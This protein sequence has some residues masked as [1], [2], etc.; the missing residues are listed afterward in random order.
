MVLDVG[1]LTEPITVAIKKISHALGWAVEPLQTVRIAKAEVKARA[2]LA[3]GDMDVADSIQQRTTQRVLQEE[4][5]KQRN[6]ESI[7][8]KA[9][10]QLREDSRP[11]HVDN[12][13][14][15]NF[16][17]RCK[18]ISDEEFQD[19]W[20]RILAGEMNRPGAFSRRTLNLVS[21]MEKVDAQLFTSLCAFCWSV[22]EEVVPLVYDIKATIYVNRGIHFTT[23]TH[24]DSI[25]LIKFSPHMNVYRLRLPQIIDAEYYG[26][27]LKLAFPKK[28]DNELDVGFVMLTR[29]GQE[30]APICG[31]EPNDEFE[32]YIRARFQ[33]YIGQK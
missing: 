22:H 11:D 33:L 27:R 1:K 16:F 18:L 19:L 8:L 3:E 21:T 7:T 23:L 5:L 15:A 6:I 31:S 28:D 26:R 25:G 20:S 12:D 13:W 29:T 4:A 30:L 17:D 10:P 24:L 9:L 2:I 14:I 32:E